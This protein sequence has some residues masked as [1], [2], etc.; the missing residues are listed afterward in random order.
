MRRLTLMLVAVLALAS[1]AAAQ[2]MPAAEQIHGRGLPTADLPDGTVTVRVVREAIGNDLPGQE[3]RIVGGARPLTATTDDFGRAE[4]KGLTP[5]VELHAEVTVNGEALRSDPFVAPQRGGLRVIL[6]AGMAGAA[7][8][9]AAEQERARA[10]PAVKGAVTLGGN[11]RIIGEFQNDALFLFYQLDIVNNARAP[12]DIGGPLDFTLP[13]RAAGASLMDGSPKTA[14][15]NGRHLVV[16]GPFA[17]G[18]TT[19]NVQ[20]QLQFPGSEAT[21]TQP[22]PL[23]VEGLPVFFEKLGTVTVTSPQLRPEGERV[24]PNGTAFLAATSEVLPAG[25]ELVL[26]LSNLPAHS[27]TPGYVAIGLALAVFA[28]GIWLSVTARQGAAAV[29]A[30]N[31]RRETLLEKLADLERARRSAKIGDEKYLTRRQRMMAELEELYHEIEL[32]SG[33][34]QGGDEGVPA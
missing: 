11:S 34:R 3:V 32:A 15:I 33:R 1:P 22:F 12:V 31:A 9:R 18:I 14:T 25:T 17:P 21:V 19:V 29:A 10:A 20:F 27:K 7:E 28:L 2:D 30:L 23:P 24:A 4:F 8:R 13:Q 5:G 26:Q 6:V 16:Q